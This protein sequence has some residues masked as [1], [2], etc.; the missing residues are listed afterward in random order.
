[1]TTRNLAS[2]NKCLICEDQKQYAPNSA[3]GI[4]YDKLACLL[5][6]QYLLIMLD[7]SLQLYIIER[8][9]IL[10]DEKYLKICDPD[11]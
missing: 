10:G 4:P 7:F 1:M 6:T 8:D 2:M 5:L 11:H 3:A 9:L